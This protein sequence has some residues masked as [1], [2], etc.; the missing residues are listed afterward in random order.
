MSFC[1][2]TTVTKNASVLA[3]CNVRLTTPTPK[4]NRSR[5]SD[6]F[7][8]TGKIKITRG[9]RNVTHI[10]GT[11]PKNLQLIKYQGFQFNKTRMCRQTR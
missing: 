9:L 5:D 7:L 4:R 10:L 2:V 8:K 11:R 6:A 3:K 1:K